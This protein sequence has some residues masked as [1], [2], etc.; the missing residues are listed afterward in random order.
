MRNETENVPKER[1]NEAVEK[2][3]NTYQTYSYCCDNLLNDPENRL[4]R[5]VNIRNPR[6]FDAAGGYED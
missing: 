6:E 5:C 4:I 3:I 1:S 2:I